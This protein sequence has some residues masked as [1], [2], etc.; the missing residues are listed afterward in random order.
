M[1]LTTTKQ[2]GRWRHRDEGK[3]TQQNTVRQ[4]GC[5]ANSYHKS[6]KSIKQP[7]AHVNYNRSLSISI[8][9]VY[10]F[11]CFQCYLPKSYIVWFSLQWHYILLP[12]PLNSITLKLVKRNVLFYLWSDN[13]ELFIHLPTAR[14]ANKNSMATPTQLIQYRNMVAV[15]NASP[16]PKALA[17]SR[18]NSSP[19]SV[20][21]VKFT[22]L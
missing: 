20:I 2:K 4:L 15:F 5:Y 7:D 11:C 10:K 3:C 12:A 21:R 22:N 18:L 19:Q 16:P 8:V 1:Q 13:K 14:T 6:W 17:S 9:N